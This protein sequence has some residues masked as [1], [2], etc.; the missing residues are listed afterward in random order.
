MGAATAVVIVGLVGLCVGLWLLRGALDP[1]SPPAAPA[2]APVHARVEASPA[3]PAAIPTPQPAVP[4]LP[5]RPE[6]PD[7]RGNDSVDPCTST[8]D[9]EV[10][11]GYETVT[12]DGV[13]V[14]WQPGATPMQGIYDVPLQPT[15]VAYLVKGL[16]TEAATLT[17]T[18]RREQLTVLVYPSK[19]SLHAA[20]HTPAWSDGVYNGGAV[21]IVAVPRADLGVEVSALRHELMHAQL[22]SAVGCMPAWFNE[23][24]ATY[25]A[26]HAPIRAWLKMLRN[27]DSFDLGSLQGSTF[28]DLPDNLADRAYAES[29]AMIVYLV[30]RS[31]ELG[32]Q[33]AI[34]T[35]QTPRRGAPIARLN[36][37]DRLFPGAGHRAVL[38]ALARKLFG[39][40]LGGELDAIFRGAVCC[41][42]LLWVTDLGC[43]G[44][45]PYP[46]Y[47]DLEHWI[48]RTSSP[49]ALCDAT[50]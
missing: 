3:A 35:L 2:P 45:P 44:I 23:G 9:P 47:P 42:S 46:G 49:R 36:L 14:A 18:A 30:Q 29:M 1:E 40:P 19:G 12:A 21:S 25:F 28:A 15:T 6:A 10:P 50:W 7:L 39:V 27:P 5:G 38:D 31:G 24:L 41:H 43:R 8:F 48:D 34:R 11:P 26:G 16:L 33:T 17:G 4:E 32:V 20:T 22:H 37:W 13:T